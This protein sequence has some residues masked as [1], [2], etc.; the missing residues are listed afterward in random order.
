MEGVRNL[1]CEPPPHTHRAREV[2][3]CVFQPASLRLTLVQYAES[4]RATAAITA[5]QL[6]MY[7]VQVGAADPQINH[8]LPA[9]QDSVDRHQRSQRP[10]APTNPLT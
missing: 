1:S 7:D 5:M 8:L 3:F 10:S 4:G 9:L 2:G 6:A